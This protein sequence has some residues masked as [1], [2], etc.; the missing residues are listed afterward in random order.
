MLQRLM[1]W[2]VPDSALELRAVEPERAD[3]GEALAP[4]EP[5]RSMADSPL[6]L[7][8]VGNS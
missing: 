4:Y 6:G 5:E 3:L 2:C 7:R 1:A 8:V